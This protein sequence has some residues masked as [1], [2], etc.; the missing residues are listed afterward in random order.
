MQ[1]GISPSREGTVTENQESDSKV[2]EEG[3]QMTQGDRSI[4]V[5]TLERLIH[6]AYDP[7]DRDVADGPLEE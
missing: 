5:V 4:D 1:T 3:R 2:R 7:L 6:V